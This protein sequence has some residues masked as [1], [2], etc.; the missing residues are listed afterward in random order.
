MTKRAGKQQT[1][2]DTKDPRI[3]KF[4]VCSGGLRGQVSAG[5][6]LGVWVFANNYQPWKLPVQLAIKAILLQEGTAGVCHTFPISGPRA[7]D[8]PES[9]TLC[10]G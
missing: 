10:P 9:Q 7:Q 4:H 1:K 2:A 3:E 5:R 6:L 8:R